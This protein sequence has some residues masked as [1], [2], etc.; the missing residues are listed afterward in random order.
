MY[1]DIWYFVIMFL[2]AELSVIYVSIK[3]SNE[4][5]NELQ[6]LEMELKDLKEE[7]ERMEEELKRK[8][9]EIKSLYDEIEDFQKKNW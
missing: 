5:L 7:R 9:N 2:I 8:N 3:M 1:Y 4:H 6:T